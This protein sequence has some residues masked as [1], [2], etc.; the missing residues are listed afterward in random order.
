MKYFGTDG[1]R[2]TFG[3]GFLTEK[4]AF[5]LG[6][7][8]G[9]FIELKNLKPKKILLAKDT[10][11]SGEILQNAFYSGLSECKISGVSAGIIPTP[12]LALC[13]SKKNFAM[14]VMITASHNP[15]HDN[16]F[17]FFN[18]NGNK[19]Q[20]SDEEI[21]EGLIEIKEGFLPNNTFRETSNSAKDL[22]FNH[23]VKNFPKGILKGKKIVADLA[24]GA[25]KETTP[26][27]LS[28]MGA[29]VISINTGNG[30]IN[31]FVGSEYP[32]V[33]SDEVKQN[34][35]DF[36]IAHD[37]DGDRVI[38]CDS[39]GRIIK[40][41]KILGLLAI[42]EKKQGRLPSN[43]IV[44]T[45]HSNS[46]LQHSLKKYEITVHTSNVGD[47]FVA[48]KLKEIN[49]TLGGES[50]GHIIA[51]NIAPSG[52]GLL[53]AL[54]ISRVLYESA[55]SLFE[56]AEQISLWPSKEGSFFVKE[57]IPLD[58]CYSLKKGLENAN[59]ILNK[60]GRILLRYS[61]T[62]PKI[63]LLVEA[64]ESTVVEKIFTKIAKIIEDEL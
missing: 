55:T 33:L 41:D 24:N 9:K 32:S 59:R 1:I 46:G 27:I 58:S 19:L 45:I 13:V 8:V 26:R 25:T 63:R 40:G 21:I 50:S 61:G 12:A 42:H 30:K 53:T 5:A 47:R 17:K 49:A 56:L 10:R 4:F 43:S 29:K 3:S 22:Y 51:N 39:E 36:G 2:S 11:P 62:E 64:K 31:D 54:L 52:D 48:Q 37:G 60:D 34:S 23:L 15:V 20:K 14:G 16:G 28:D 18:S 38:F 7:A 44:A 35:A 57:K 6:E